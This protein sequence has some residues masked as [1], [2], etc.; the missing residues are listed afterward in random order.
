MEGMAIDVSL[1]E[2]STFTSGNTTA[3]GYSIVRNE[4]EETVDLF[5]K[6]GELLCCDG[7]ECVVV[8]V[9]DNAIMLRALE[10]KDSFL[11][12]RDEAQVAIFR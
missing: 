11:L 6:C 5:G 10:A 7:E 4:E 12:T 8:H 3:Y 2:L 9:A 1:H